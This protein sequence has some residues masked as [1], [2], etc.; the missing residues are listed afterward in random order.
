MLSSLLSLSA[1]VSLALAQTGG[2]AGV[3][4]GNSDLSQLNSL[5]GAFPGL[6]TAL[7]SATNIT[8]LA[9]NNAAL[10]TLLNST[11]GKALAA[12]SDAVEALLMYHVLKGVIPASAITNMSAFAPTLLDNS[13][14]SNVTGGQVVEAVKVNSGVQIFSGLLQNSTVTQAVRINRRF[15][16]FQVSYHRI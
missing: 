15:T 9:P 5:L 13:T 16:V 7:S 12:D 8:L 1:I 10:G 3:L 2:L 4:S 6:V 14:Y 11:A